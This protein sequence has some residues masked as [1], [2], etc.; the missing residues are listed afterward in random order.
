MEHATLAHWQ[1]RHD[2]PQA[3]A[4]RGN[5]LSPRCVSPSGLTP[6]WKLAYAGCS[7]SVP[8]SP[9]SHSS[10]AVPSL[11]LMRP[12][13]AQVAL[14]SSGQFDQAEAATVAEHAPGQTVGCRHAGG[15][16]RGQE[17]AE[18]DVRWG[19]RNPRLTDASTTPAHS[20]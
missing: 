1:R 18:A 13:L 4:P 9:A 7:C 2:G 8:S 15:W 10:E 6:P 11:S 17:N 16:G 5:R 14:D 12:P 20:R 19:K 3:W